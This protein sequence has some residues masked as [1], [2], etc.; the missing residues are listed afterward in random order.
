G[1]QLVPRTELPRTELPMLTFDIQ[2]VK[3]AVVVAERRERTIFLTTIAPNGPAIL[4]AFDHLVTVSRTIDRTPDFGRAHGRATP[5][6]G[7]AMRAVQQRPKA[8]YLAPG[9]HAPGR[10]WR[11]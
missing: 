7:I 2:N 9:A 8:R 5:A 10:P 6:A 4:A 11:R 1:E 3:H